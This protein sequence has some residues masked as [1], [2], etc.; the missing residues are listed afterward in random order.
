MNV[1]STRSQHC[2][3]SFVFIFKDHHHHHHV[4]MMLI[5]DAYIYIYKV[6]ERD[7][8]KREKMVTLRV[9]ESP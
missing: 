4:F 6:G 9:H 2:L 7:L 1:P 5:H 8:I 3:L